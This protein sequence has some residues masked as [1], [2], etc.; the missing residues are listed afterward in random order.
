MVEINVLQKPEWISWDEI[1]DLLFEAHKKNVENGMSMRIPHLPG[2]ELEKQ[3][4]SSGRCFVAIAD[5][6]LVGTTSV[7][8]FKGHSWY[9]EGKLVAHSMLSGILPKYQGIG[10]TE[11]LNELRDEFIREVGA[12]MIHADTAENNTVVREKVRKNGFYDVAYKVRETHNS[13]IFVKWLD[14]SPF[15]DKYINR[16]FKISKVLARIQFKPGKVE[17]SHLLTVLCKILKKVFNVE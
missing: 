17:R 4:G 2:E 8:F 12:T 10:I 7:R 13:I 16:K 1:H 15:S 5:G 3:L 14:R 9:D 11:D 6:K